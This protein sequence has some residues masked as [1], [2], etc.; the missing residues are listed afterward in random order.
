MHC[1]WRKIYLHVHCTFYNYTFIKSIGGEVIST[2]YHLIVDINVPE[3]PLPG[4]S[5]VLACPP[6]VAHLTSKSLH[7]AK[8]PG[9]QLESDV[10]LVAHRVQLRSHHSVAALL[11]W[12]LQPDLI[13]AKMN[14][15]VREVLN[16]V[17]KG[18]GHSGPIWA[19][20][21]SH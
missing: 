8:T 14:V 20:M 18:G 10:S 1:S 13:G 9:A 17:G 19:I 3:Q 15:T 4:V 7:I 2:G 5:D 11:R 6:K 16:Q 12:I 21:W